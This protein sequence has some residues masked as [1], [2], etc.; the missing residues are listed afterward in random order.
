MCFYLND[1]IL[2]AGKSWNGTDYDF[3]IARF[4]NEFIPTAAT[5]SVAGQ[6]LNS[7]GRPVFGAT[8]SVTDLN[9]YTRTTRTNPLGYYRFEELQV[10]E[11]YIFNVV[12]KRYQFDAQ[13]INVTEEL[14]ELNFVALE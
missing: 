7:H 11:T 10:G 12:S 4:E 3:A 8:V 9:G 6:V 5:V 13:A 2:A 1:K 14:T